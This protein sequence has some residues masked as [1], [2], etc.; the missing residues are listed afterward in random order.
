VVLSLARV[1]VSWVEETKHAYRILVGKPVGKPKRVMKD[2]KSF[3]KKTDFCGV[4]WLE[5]IQK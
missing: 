3:I 5:Q 1:D 4:N 2:V